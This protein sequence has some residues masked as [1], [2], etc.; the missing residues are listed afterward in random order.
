MKSDTDPG[1]RSAFR[2][3]CSEIDSDTP[4]AV[5][6]GQLEERDCVKGNLSN[7]TDT[8]TKKMISSDLDP[9]RI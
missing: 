6:V 4:S 1:L 5:T 9:T 2:Y 7:H 8:Q 3:M